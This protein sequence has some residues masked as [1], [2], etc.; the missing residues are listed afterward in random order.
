MMQRL[1]IRAPILLLG[2]I[3][4]TVFLEPVLTLVLLAM[5]PFVGFSVF[6][7]SRKGIPLYTRL[8]KSIDTMV[9]IVRENASGIRVIKALSKRNM[10]KLAL[11]K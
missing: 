3:T 9:R 1:G 2:G 4:I 7:I 8:Q 6:F 5:F 10:R 11:P